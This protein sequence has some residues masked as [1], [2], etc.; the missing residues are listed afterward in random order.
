MKVYYGVVNDVVGLLIIIYNILGC[1]II[2]MSLEI[3]VELFEICVNIKGVK[4][5]IVDLVC[6]FC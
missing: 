1:F 4:D 5:V 2:D 6:V 3:M